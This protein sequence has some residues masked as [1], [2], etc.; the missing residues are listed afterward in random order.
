MKL[1]KD[2]PLVNVDYNE[3]ETT[4]TLDFIDKKQ[5]NLLE[6]VI[7]TEAYD[8]SSEKFQP[9]KEVAA[10]AEE[11]AQKYFSTSFAELGDAVGSEHDVYDYGS[12]AKVYPVDIVAKFDTAM[13]GKTITGKISKVEDTGTALEVRFDYEDNTYR[14]NYR[15]SKWLESQKKA[16]PIAGKKPKAL[17]RFQNATGVDF[18]DAKSL[19]G[20]EALFK[21]RQAGK[22][23]WSELV[24]VK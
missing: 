9:D 23:T 4:A 22:N 10:R 13:V 12:F 3:N 6:M 20:K 11:I 18:K 24:A 17:E 2:L 5:G 1:Y 19:V 16:L 14:T 8:Q 21:V 7:H 15:Y